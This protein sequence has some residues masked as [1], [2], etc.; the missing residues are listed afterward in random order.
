MWGGLAEKPG[1]VKEAHA[2]PHL[3]VTRPRSGSA[4]ETYSRIRGR[5]WGGWVLRVSWVPPRTTHNWTMTKWASVPCSVFRILFVFCF[6]LVQTGELGRGG[7]L[8]A[9]FCFV[10]PLPHSWK[11]V[12]SKI[13]HRIAIA[14][15]RHWFPVISNRKWGHWNAVWSFAS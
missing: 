14:Q 9:S 8:G 7:A 15:H 10:L 1:V 12:Y 2:G 6:W 5:R 4:W 3:A 13:C 11:N